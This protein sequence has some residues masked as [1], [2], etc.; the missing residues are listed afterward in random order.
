MTT[1]GLC[2]VQTANGDDAMDWR[3]PVSE[4]TLGR[5]RKNIL[6]SAEAA[7]SP[8]DETGWGCVGE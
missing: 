3:G 7:K 6:C 8:L 5:V 1:E 2:Y 4:S